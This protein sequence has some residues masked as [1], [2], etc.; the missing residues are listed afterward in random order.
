M[1]PVDDDDILSSSV[2]PPVASQDDAPPPF[3]EAAP[4]TQ[5]AALQPEVKDDLFSSSAVPVEREIDLEDDD[6]DDIFK[7]ARLE[8]E[9]AKVILILTRAE[10][11]DT[12]GVLIISP[13]VGGG[14]LGDSAVRLTR[15]EASTPRSSP[16]CTCLPPPQPGVNKKPL[17]WLPSYQVLVGT[18]QLRIQP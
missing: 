6:D 9:P 14:G 2:T 11:F 7:L 8:P 5:A 16:L 13:T 15:R 12:V 1:K 18:N 3:K 17:T 4:A 10:G